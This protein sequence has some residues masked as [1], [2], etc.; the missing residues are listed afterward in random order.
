MVEDVDEAN[1]RHLDRAA[2]R[3]IRPPMSQ[4]GSPERFAVRKDERGSTYA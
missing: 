4:R 1:R 3:G 2:P